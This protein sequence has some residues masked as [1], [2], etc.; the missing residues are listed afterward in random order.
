[1]KKD[2]ALLERYAALYRRKERLEK[3]IAI[4]GCLSCGYVIVGVFIIC[5]YGVLSYSAT[6]K[7]PARAEDVFVL[8]WVL[9]AAVLCFCSLAYKFVQESRDM[10]ADPSVL[11][12]LF[13]KQ[14][15]ISMTDLQVRA[16]LNMDAVV[17]LASGKRR[18]EYTLFADTP[19]LLSLCG[20]ECPEKSEK[21]L[22]AEGRRDELDVSSTYVLD[23]IQV[24]LFQG[25]LDSKDPAISS[26]TDPFEV[27]FPKDQYTGE[28]CGLLDELCRGIVDDVVHRAIEAALSG[29]KGSWGQLRCGILSCDMVGPYFTC[30]NGENQ[31][32]DEKKARL[33]ELLELCRNGMIEKTMSAAE[34]ECAAPTPAGSPALPPFGKEGA[35]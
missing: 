7:L 35:L 18:F 2:D 16:A 22:I 26:E 31:A 33:N 10:M 34:N 30:E 9:S 11:S 21:I 29:K 12:A 25:V 13:N 5:I 4:G 32:L 8:S 15:Y 17:D 1:M 3:A 14:S 24:L 6:S 19:L 28:F 27:I 20:D 23:C